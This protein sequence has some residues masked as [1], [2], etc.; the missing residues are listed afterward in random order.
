MEAHEISSVK[1]TI[2]QEVQQADVKKVQK[3]L[4]AATT[5]WLFHSKVSPRL[6]SRLAFRLI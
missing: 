1:G 4:K 2:F 6:V 3:L 5:W